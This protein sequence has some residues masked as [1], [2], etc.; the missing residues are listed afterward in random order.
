[1]AF[2][3]IDDH[4]I[5]YTDTG[6]NKP[7][8]I[9]SHGFFLD[10]KSFDLQYAYFK[11]T[12]RCIGWD[13][14]GFGQS[15]TSTNYSYW[16]S[17]K[18]LLA[19]M[20]HLNIRKAT[21]IGVSKGGFISLRAA[22]TAPDRV[23]NLVLIGSDSGVFGAE[24]QA[25]FTGLIDAWGTLGNDELAD[26]MAAVGETY[27]G[28]DDQKLT[29]IQTW[30]DRDRAQIKFPG[31]ALLNRD[32]ISQRVQEISCPTLVIHGTDDQA[33]EITKA[34]AM[35]ATLPNS[36]FLSIDGAPHGPNMTHSEIV[37]QKIHAFLTSC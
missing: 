27:F 35:A 7:V 8:L 1:M 3:D 34:E 6:G 5:F 17:A 4:K 25:E 19:L 28:D 12:Y 26:A 36:D 24:Q 21:L 33:I 30:R 18:V 22:L 15:T 37:N 31:H 9:F 23:T 29:W 16:D 13:E 11:D 14:M 10:Q 32:D 2:F 20:D